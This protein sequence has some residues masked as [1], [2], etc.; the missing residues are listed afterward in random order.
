VKKLTDTGLCY[1]DLSCCVSC[2]SCV[3][4]GKQEFPGVSDNF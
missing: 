3:G 1:N 2:A 4:Q